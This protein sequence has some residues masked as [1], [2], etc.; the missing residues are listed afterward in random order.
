MPPPG[1]ARPPPRSVRRT[2]N[3]VTA[4]QR[5]GW[6]CRARWTSAWPAP[7]QRGELPEPGQLRG[8]RSHAR[9][10]ASQVI[11]AFRRPCRHAPGTRHRWRGRAHARSGRSHAAGGAAAPLPN[12]PPASTRRPPSHPAPRCHTPCPTVAPAGRRCDGPPGCATPRNVCDTAE[13]VRRA[14]GAQR[15]G[16]DARRERSN[17]PSS[18]HVQRTTCRPRSRRASSR[19]FSPV[20]GL[21]GSSPGRRLAAVL[22]LPVELADRAELLPVEVGADAQL[23]NV[24][25][26]HRRREAEPARSPPGC[27]SPPGSPRAGRRRR[28]PVAP[29]GCPPDRRPGRRPPRRP[30]ESPGARAVQRPP[31]PAPARTAACGP[32]RPACA[33]PRS[34]RRRRPRR[35]RR[36]PALP[37][38]RAAPWCAGRRSGGSV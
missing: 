19:R 12:A 23:G 15:P 13:S 9:R 26:Q 29:A 25:L 35:P 2:S 33:A 31:P 5:S 32:G 16:A 6:C 17:V 37:C 28:R 38:A 8:L 27:A 18:S 7:A 10:V 21:P 36:R 22:D 20:H 24:V 4:T 3:T 11:S 14:H 30:P 1:T 34:P